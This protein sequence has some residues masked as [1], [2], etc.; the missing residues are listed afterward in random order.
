ML[1]FR[2]TAAEF[3]C[4]KEWNLYRGVTMAIAIRPVAMETKNILTCFYGATEVY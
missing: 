2:Q 3:G 4:H 1:L